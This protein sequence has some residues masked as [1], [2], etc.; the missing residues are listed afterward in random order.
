MKH[1]R[2]L[3]TALLVLMI[4]TIGTSSGAAAPEGQMT[5]GV[6]ITLAS[7]WPYRARMLYNWDAVQFALATPNW[8]IQ[9]GISSD[10]P[11]R[12]EVVAASEQRLH[13]VLGLHLLVLGRPTRLEAGIVDGLRRH[14]A[15]RGRAGPARAPRTP[16]C[17]G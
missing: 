5:W 3:S 15:G 4:L 11:W 9:E 1:V 8:L 2:G 6:H 16:S 13:F 12:D 7:R 17:R 10:V 14:R